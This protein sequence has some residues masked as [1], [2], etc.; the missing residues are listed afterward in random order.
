MVVGAHAPR[1]K[2]VKTAD[3]MVKMLKTR[4]PCGIQKVWLTSSSGRLPVLSGSQQSEGVGSS[5]YSSS[6]LRSGIL[7]DCGKC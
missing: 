4:C 3:K 2:E 1:L 6:G 7:L 5:S